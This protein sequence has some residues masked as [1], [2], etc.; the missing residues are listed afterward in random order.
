M[1]GVQETVKVLELA[2]K[3]HQRQKLHLNG[4]VI[5]ILAEL[6]EEIDL[7]ESFVFEVLI[8]WVSAYTANSPVFRPFEKREF[9]QVDPIGVLLQS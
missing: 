8:V 5:E 9:D 1:H 6:M 2:L 4:L 7:N 3:S